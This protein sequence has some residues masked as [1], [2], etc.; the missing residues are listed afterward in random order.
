MSEFPIAWKNDLLFNTQYI[1][2]Y[3]TAK[4]GICLWNMYIWDMNTSSYK[5]AVF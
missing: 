4:D 2:Q 5:D 1:L 3:I